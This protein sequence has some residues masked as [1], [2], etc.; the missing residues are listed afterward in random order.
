MKKM[1]NMTHYN[2]ELACQN[3]AI[4]RFVDF[5]VLSPAQGHLKT[6]SN[7]NP[8]VYITPVKTIYHD[9]QRASVHK[10]NIG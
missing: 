5:G 1:I 10:Q 6:N 7:K 9:E 8:P 3:K 2:N 4:S